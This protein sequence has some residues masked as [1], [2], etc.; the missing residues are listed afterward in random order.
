MS[1]ST[2]VGGKINRRKVMLYAL[3][4]CV[5]CKKTKRLLDGLGVA[6]DFIDVDLLKGREEEEAMDE[7]KRHNPDCTFPTMI[8]DGRQVIAGFKEDEIRKALG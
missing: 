6:Y 3:S 4:T 7:V 2:S 5:W 1:K 8:I